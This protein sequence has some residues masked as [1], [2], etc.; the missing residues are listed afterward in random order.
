MKMSGKSKRVRYS[1]EETENMI[2]NDHYSGDS[3]IDLGEDLSDNGW[4]TCRI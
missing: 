4:V 1:A 2:P 3:D